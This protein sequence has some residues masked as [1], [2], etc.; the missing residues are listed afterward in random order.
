MK[1]RVLFGVVALVLI[2]STVFAGPAQAAALIQIHVGDVK[3]KY[4]PLFAGYLIEVHVLVLSATNEAVGGAKVTTALGKPSSAVVLQTDI[5]DGYGAA[6][7]KFVVGS[8]G[9]YTACVADVALRGAVYNAK[10][11]V[12]TCTTL[13]IPTPP[14]TEPIQSGPGSLEPVSDGVALTD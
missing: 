6:V 13:Q 5:S 8:V 4:Y 11:N 12:K 10:M 2:L 3:A 1:H 7:F 9:T 14:T